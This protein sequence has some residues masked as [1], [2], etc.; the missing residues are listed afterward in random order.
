MR[1]LKT[2]GV[3]SNQPIGRESNYPYDAAH[4]HAVLMHVP[5]TQA[6]LA[7]VNRVIKTRRHCRQP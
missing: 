1:Y 2:I 5:D 7:E 6:A 3:N 4:C